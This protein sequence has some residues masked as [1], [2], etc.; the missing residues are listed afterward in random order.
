M[1]DDLRVRQRV[2]L[3]LWT[4]T[5]DGET[6]MKIIQKF[7]GATAALALTAG[8]ALADPALI[9]DLGG[10]FDKSFNKLRIMALKNGKPKPAAITLI[11]NCNQKPSA[12]KRYAALPNLAPTQSLLQGLPFHRCFPKSPPIIQ[13]QNSVS[14]MAGH[15]RI[16]F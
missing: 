12:S 3:F 7:L 4:Q 9:Y 6:S 8:A 11:S 14:L 10:K 15:P 1:M 13:I 16:M 5:Q 2:L